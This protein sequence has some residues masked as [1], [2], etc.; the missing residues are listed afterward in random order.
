MEIPSASG[1]GKNFRTRTGRIVP[2]HA[3]SIRVSDRYIT[4]LTGEFWTSRQ[5][6][7]NSLHEISYRACYKAELPG[8]FIDEFPGKGTRL[9]DP[10]SGRGTTVLEGIIRGIPGTGMD[11]NPLSS[12][13]ASPRW[14]IPS[15]AKIIKRLKYIFRNLERRE[16][17]IDLSMFY[18]KRTEY[19]IVQLKE[20]LSDRNESGTEDDT[21]RWIRMV[22]TSRLTGH[23]RGFFSVYTLP[24]NQATSPRRQIEIN[25]KL[26][27]APEYRDVSGIIVRKTKSLLRDV[28]ERTRRNINRVGRSSKIIAED[29]RRVSEYVDENSIDLTVTSPP[30]LNVVQYAKDNW[31]RCWF[32]SIDLGE[33][34]RK[35][36][37]SGN[38][39]EWKNF[40]FSVLVELHK[41]TTPG[42]H[43]A[44]EVGEV[45]HRKKILNLDEVVGGLAIKAGFTLDCIFVNSQ[46][47]T[48]TSNIWGI[49]N[50]NKG[51]NTNRIVLLEK[52][53]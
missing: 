46:K 14:E 4:R 40:I 35:L 12:I 1:T 32:N 37:V 53:S 24:P 7:S 2:V 16:A 30:F 38:L 34:E 11:S 5:R 47:F 28:D 15:E 42:G 49:D 27:N 26:G 9:F 41:I 10:F 51:T 23:S 8:F 18:H 3:E 20:Y 17:D 44:F 19:E 22:A 33:I 31:L 21:D 45:H 36:F 50:Q 13:I 39:V 6:R 43:V 29:S 52:K 48:K 25:R